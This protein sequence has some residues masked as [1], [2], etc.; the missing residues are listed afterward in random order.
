MLTSFEVGVGGGAL[1]GALV[2]SEL[3]AATMQ[4]AM[5][6]AMSRKSGMDAPL[7]NENTEPPKAM[8]PE[9]GGGL[10]HA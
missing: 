2:E 7:V 4:S 3:H 10:Q 1:S 9:A 8:S 6:P 5:E